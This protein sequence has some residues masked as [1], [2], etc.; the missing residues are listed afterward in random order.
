[1]SVAK[2]IHA[3][4][5]TDFVFTHYMDSEIKNIWSIRR[6]QVRHT[7]NFHY[8]IFFAFCVAASRSSSSD[9][10][11][12]DLL[13]K[14]QTLCFFFSGSFMCTRERHVI[15]KFKYF[16]HSKQHLKLSSRI[17]QLQFLCLVILKSSL[18]NGTCCWFSRIANERR[19]P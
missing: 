1:M 12:Y 19:A 11:K 5:I 17:T 15:K 7:E 3:S 4:T 6:H 2:N 14:N 10:D 9:L 13:W 16:W 8:S 18:C